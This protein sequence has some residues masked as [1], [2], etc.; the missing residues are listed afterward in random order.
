MKKTIF[1]L[2]FTIVTSCDNS[3]EK[4]RGSN[5]GGNGGNGG[6]QSSGTGGES[7]KCP[8]YEP[9][10]IHLQTPQTRDQCTSQG[11]TCTTN[12]GTNICRGIGEGTGF[13]EGKC[14][15]DGTNWICTPHNLSKNNG[16]PLNPCGS[17]K[18]QEAPQTPKQNLLYCTPQN[19]TSCQTDSWEIC[20]DG[21]KGQTVTWTCSCQE[22]GSFTCTPELKN[23]VIC[24]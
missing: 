16:C 22:N 24:P 13:V 20:P 6:E 18:P 9:M 5:E 12:T 19:H 3:A 17:I 4:T 11:Q 21:S 10:D 1:I 23:D 2:M 14:T 8:K 15:C 7:N